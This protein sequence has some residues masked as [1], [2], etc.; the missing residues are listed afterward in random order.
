MP[1]IGVIG[2]GAVSGYG[3]LPTIRESA[4]WTLAGVAERDPS[5]LAAVAS[6]YRPGLATTDWRELLASPGLD[7][8]VIA[9]HA[10][11]HREIACAA[12]AAGIDV[13]CEKP[14]AAD[15]AQC[16]EMVAAAERSGRLLAINFNSRSVGVMREAKRLI[17]DGAVGAVRVVRFVYAWSAHQWR[18]PERFDAFMRNGGPIVDSGSTSSTRR[19]GS[20]VRSSRA[21]TLPA[22]CCRRTP[23][24]STSRRPA[25]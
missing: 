24:R 16:R 6:E 25:A 5:R 20:P 15:A 23:R 18:P 12:L 17:D 19:A 4:E 8:V 7:A 3:H 13:L 1:T 11:S 10:E 9:T 14:M 2:C 22:W 21:S